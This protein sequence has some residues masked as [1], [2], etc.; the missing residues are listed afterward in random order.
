MPDYILVVEDDQNLAVTIGMVLEGE[1]YAIR[2]ARNG[3]QALEAVAKQMPSL[4]IL[5]MLMPIM[6]GW[7]FSR[8]LHLQY[9]HAA[10]ILVV[11]AAE[12][13][14][15][16]GLD[17]QASAVLAKPFDVQRLLD[18]VKRLIASQPAASAELR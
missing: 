7:E 2:I 17:V 9:A 15:T 6:D 12:N 14:T 16:R 10:P 3:R 18:T 1:G 13:P 4:I 5:D 11:T 8:E